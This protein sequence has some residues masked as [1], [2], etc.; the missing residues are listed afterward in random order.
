M[1]A[2]PH[3]V[4]LRPWG[5]NSWLVHYDGPYDNDRERH[6]SF[7]AACMDMPT[8]GQICKLSDLIV[9][10]PSCQWSVQGILGDPQV[11]FTV[12]Y[13]SKK[14]RSDFEWTGNGY[15]DDT[16]AKITFL[17]KFDGSRWEVAYD[18]PY[19]PHE[20]Y[21]APTVW[22]G[23]DHIGMVH[24]GLVCVL[25]NLRTEDDAYV[26][27]VKGIPYVP[28]AQFIVARNS[29]NPLATFLWEH[30]LSMSAYAFRTITFYS[31]WGRSSWLVSYDGPYDN[32]DRLPHVVL[33]KDYMD[34]VQSRELCMLSNLR[35]QDHLCMWTV[36]GVQCVPDAVFIVGYNSPKPR[37]YFL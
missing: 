10:G 26:W 28:R 30:R 5:P 23:S 29:Q 2:A 6:V 27:G 21:V 35:V 37:S 15:I 14:P 17:R 19:E 18:G 7:E 3:I 34:M 36:N 32:P 31:K 16:Q 9:R 24:A 20:K 25:F 4:F 1:E 11:H 13:G 8:A 12:A 22:L 33:G